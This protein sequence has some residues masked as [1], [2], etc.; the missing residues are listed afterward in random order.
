[1]SKTDYVIREDGEAAMFTA[2]SESELL[3]TDFFLDEYYNYIQKA[4][5]EEG[6]HLRYYFCFVF[7]EIV[8]ENRVVGFATYDIR[9]NYTLI[10]TECYILPQFRGKRLFFD[11]ICRMHFA[12]PEFGILQP[13][14]NVIDLLLSYAFA[15]E[16][17]DDIVVSAIGLYLDP[18]LMESNKKGGPINLLVPPTYFYDLSISS[19]LF[20]HEDEVF[21]HMLL[22]NDCL[23]GHRRKKLGKDYFSKII[24]IFSKNR[25]KFENLIVELKKELPDNRLGYDVIV[26]FGSGLSDYMQGMVDQDILSFDRA[27]AIKKQLKEEYEKGKIDDGNVEAR[28]NDLSL[29]EYQIIGSFSD[30]KKLADSNRLDD[31]DELGYFRELV[32]LAGDNYELGNELFNALLKGN[33]AEF[34]DI[35]M[36]QMESD[37]EFSH[38]YIDLISEEF[39]PETYGKSR[40]TF[41]KKNL[42]DKYRLS[43]REYGDCPVGYEI[44]LYLI[45]DTLNQGNNYYD[46]LI[47]LEWDSLA[48]A[49]LITE[50]LL[51]SGFIEADG[52]IEIDWTDGASKLNN[53]ELRNVLASNGLGFEGS[54]EELLK[55]LQVNNITLGDAY[56]ITSK[57]KDYLKKHYWIG[58]YWDFI[59]EFDFN[60][61]FEYLNS[62][63]GDL[64][65]VSLNYLDEHIALA[66]KIS[67]EEYLEDCMDAKEFI[68]DGYDEFLDEI[69]DIG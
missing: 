40:K 17:G 9:N 1:M 57:G 63:R 38:R 11:E 66:E 19:T 20:V 4:M 28:F 23:R 55:R 31:L 6:Y 42:E 45:L 16:A 3:D 51:E 8:F 60:D 68:E 7:K 5:M 13:T 34:T 69:G 32:S 15:K 21:F 52:I 64:K 44:E 25:H 65:E 10:L 2:E 50:L 43:Y 14:R 24:G 54:R 26:G 22:E 56:K 18:I 49:D 29:G 41:V 39:D 62:H 33:M 59:V 30:L 27:V 12:S 61:Y 67:D 35:L 53:D 46:A 58:F 48:P 36:S 47:L 37:V